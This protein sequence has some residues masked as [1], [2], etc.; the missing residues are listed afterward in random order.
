MMASRD[1]LTGFQI[2]GGNMSVTQA[3]NIDAGSIFHADE[4]STHLAFILD[5]IA[6]SGSPQADLSSEPGYILS[7][8]QGC[9]IR[10]AFKYK[11]IAGGLNFN[12][13]QL[14]IAAK[15]GLSSVYYKVEAP[16]LGTGALGIILGA[17]PQE[18]NLDDSSYTGM[19]QNLITNL[20]KYMVDTTNTVSVVPIRTLSKVDESDEIEIT[21]AVLFGMKMIIGRLSLSEAVMQQASGAYDHDLIK[22]AY[23]IVMP[24]KEDSER[25]SDADAQVAKAW[26]RLD[27]QK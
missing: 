2:V 9:G 20:V 21:K 8:Y 23:R 26:L 14:G 27:Y 16:G 19:I 6:Y 3:I 4:K 25:P 7:T 12:F 5:S 11:M 1:S 18:G 22:Y 10:I 15:A 13:A 24:N 17:I